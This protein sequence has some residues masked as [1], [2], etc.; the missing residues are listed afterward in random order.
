[1]TTEEHEGQADTL[2]LINN[3]MSARLARQLDAGAK[4]DTKAAVVA[5]FAAT[6]TQ[7]LAIRHDYRL[8]PAI[9]AFAAYA[10]AFLAGVWALAVTT[11]EDVPEP[12]ALVDRYAERPKVTALASLAS[13][14]VRA[15]EKNRT[16]HTHKVTR[17]WISVAALGAGLILS[18]VAI[19]NTSDHGGRA[20]PREQAIHTGSHTPG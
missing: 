12:R 18:A 9:L 15:F 11:Y 4:V 8:I 20:A 10:V 17:W 16:K 1:M 2:E 14:R 3:E 6:A 5:G 7:F 13:T 19:V